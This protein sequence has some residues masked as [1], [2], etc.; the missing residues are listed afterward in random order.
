MGLLLENFSWYKAGKLYEDN[1]Y[2]C[3]IMLKGWWSA[4]MMMR[5]EEHTKKGGC[6]W[7]SHHQWMT[8]L[9]GAQQGSTD[10]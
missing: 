7:S 4:M 9:M 5:P 8:L 3:A 10:G 6:K 1:E 2:L